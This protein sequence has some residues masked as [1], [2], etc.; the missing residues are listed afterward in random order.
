MRRT[1]VMN[2]QNTYSV[3]YTVVFKNNVQKQQY[4]SPQCNKTFS[5]SSLK[6]QF[7]IPSLEK[8]KRQE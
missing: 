1:L 5:C 8:K 2:K 4:L 3:A 6:F 7:E